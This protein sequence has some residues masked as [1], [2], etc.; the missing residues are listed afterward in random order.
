MTVVELALRLTDQPAWVAVETTDLDGT[1]EDLQLE[2]GATLATLVRVQDL[3]DDAL[4]TMERE[5][6]RY[7][8]DGSVVFLGSADQLGRVATLA[9]HCWSLVGPDYWELESEPG[10]DV[11]ERLAAL[12]EQT[13]LSDAD[14]LA[15]ARA[16]TLS[17][18]PLWAEWLALLGQGEL[19]GQG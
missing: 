19:L 11:E 12:R 1:F 2:L 17:G 16:G 15:S 9:P 10:L 18:D 13:G 8:G 3:D 6:S 7:V 4:L 5:R 14:V